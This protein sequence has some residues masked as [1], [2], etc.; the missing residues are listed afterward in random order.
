MTDNAHGVLI[1]GDGNILELDNG[2]GYI[3]GDVLHATEFD[4]LKWLKWRHLLCI[5]P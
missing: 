3:L 1:C 4:T 2:D 5:L